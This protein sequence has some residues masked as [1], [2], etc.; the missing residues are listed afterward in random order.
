MPIPAEQPLEIAEPALDRREPLAERAE[1]VAI[2]PQLGQRL[3]DPAAGVLA[4]PCDLIA[5]CVPAASD[6]LPG[7]V[8]AAAELITCRLGATDELI[9]QLTGALPGLRGRAGGGGERALDR[10]PERVADALGLRLLGRL[11]SIGARHGAEL[12]A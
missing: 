3:R 1:V 9:E 11:L 12:T 2:D 7:C 6:L 10:G 5:G 8:A 4:A